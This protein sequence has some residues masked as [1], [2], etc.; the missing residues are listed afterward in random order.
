MTCKGICNQHKAP[1]PVGGSGRYS[2][3]Q[4]RRV[5]CEMFI[6]W[7]GLLCP[8]FGY[9]LRT[10]PRNT[11]DRRRNAMDLSNASFKNKSQLLLVLYR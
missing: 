2:T 5:I 6:K 10:K 4:R 1:R 8:C 11:I 3:G 7:D 9:R